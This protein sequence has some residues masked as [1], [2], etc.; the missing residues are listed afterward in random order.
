M[1]RM[2]KPEVM[3]PIVQTFYD[4]LVKSGTVKSSTRAL[5]HLDDA[6]EAWDVMTAAAHRQA[7]RMVPEE[8]MQKYRRRVAVVNDLI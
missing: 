3:F 7:M 4:H 2:K 6:I 5:K 8:L 1:P